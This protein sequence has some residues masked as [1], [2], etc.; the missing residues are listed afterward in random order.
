MEKCLLLSARKY[1][2]EDNGKRV[3]GVSLVYLTDNIETTGDRRG[4]EPLK[5]S[6]PLDVL[7]HLQAV[8]G[9]YQMDFKQ[10]PGKNGRPTLQVVSVAFV[11]ARDA[12]L[13]PVS[14]Q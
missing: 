5:I 9:V 3:E 14:A 7:P 12:F 2:F 1:D 13:S 4:C 6:A 11:E 10:R 8:P